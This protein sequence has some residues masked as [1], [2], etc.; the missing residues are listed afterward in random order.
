MQQKKQNVTLSRIQEI[1]D[2]YHEIGVRLEA[3]I[4]VAKMNRIKRLDLKLGTVT[5]VHFHKVVDSMARIEADAKISM[6][7]QSRRD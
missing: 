1:P 5:G 3:I 4:A 2:S 7:Q 6:D